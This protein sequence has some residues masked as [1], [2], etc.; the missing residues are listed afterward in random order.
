M[1][2]SLYLSHFARDNKQGLQ[3]ETQTIANYSKVQ[4]WKKKISWLAKKPFKVQ[5]SWIEVCIAA[6]DVMSQ[7]TGRDN[8]L[9]YIMHWFTMRKKRKKGMAQGSKRRRHDLC[10]KRQK[11]WQQYMPDLLGHAAQGHNC[12][13]IQSMWYNI[14]TPVTKH[15]RWLLW[16]TVLC[17]I[18]SYLQH[19]SQLERL[20]IKAIRR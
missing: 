16:L 15:E 3:W 20:W 11:Q 14:S 4:V 12:G 2:L 18:S 7:L 19:C 9:R 5:K 13:K 17:H 6:T 1:V 8:T 10:T